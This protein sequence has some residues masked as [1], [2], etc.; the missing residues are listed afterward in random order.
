MMM[1]MGGEIYDMTTGDPVEEMERYHINHDGKT[2]T[3]RSIQ[4]YK[5]IPYKEHVL[6][7]G[8]D[9]LHED[10]V[11]PVQCSI[12]DPRNKYREIIPNMVN[13][14]SWNSVG[15]ALTKRTGVPWILGGQHGDFHGCTNI[16]TIVAQLL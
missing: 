16:C 10:I 15:F 13:N 7:C 11:A 14:G 1:D 6:A 5:V 2:E 8:T 4:R 12:I 3:G 9:H